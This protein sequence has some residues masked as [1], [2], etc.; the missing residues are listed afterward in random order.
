MSK[1]LINK[2]FGILILN[3]NGSSVL[4]TPFT[5]STQH[6]GKF[7]IPVTCVKAI[8]DSTLNALP[9][10]IFHHHLFIFPQKRKRRE[11]D[12]SDAVSLSSFDF[13]VMSCFQ[14]HLC[15]CFHAP[16][17][18]KIMC[19]I[20]KTSG[21]ISCQ[22]HR[23]LKILVLA[24]GFICYIKFYD[25]KREEKYLFLISPFLN[26]SVQ[27]IF[28]KQHYLQNISSCL[29]TLKIQRWSKLKS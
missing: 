14:F 10:I 11:K 2:N 28:F 27:F 18:R 17:L 5:C 26:S 16:R 8:V 4:L 3:N 1:I 9:N 19:I 13:K 22:E 29:M 7:Q 21:E 24:L 20:E 12:D 6:R 23:F 25:Q 15:L